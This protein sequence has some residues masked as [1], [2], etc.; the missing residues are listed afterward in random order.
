MV[1]VSV[2]ATPASGSLFPIGTTTVTVVATDQYNNSSSTTFTVTVVGVPPVIVVPAT[3]RVDASASNCGAVVN[4]AATETT[5][6]PAST[7]TY[8]HQPGSV[9]SH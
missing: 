1:V 4:F 7:I 5:A 9:P 6:I 8:S 3:I 2:V